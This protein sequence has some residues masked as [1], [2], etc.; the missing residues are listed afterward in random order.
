[1]FDHQLIPCA[2]VYVDSTWI[3][4]GKGVDLLQST[5]KPCERLDGRIFRAPSLATGRDC[6]PSVDAARPSLVHLASLP[7]P[8]DGDPQVNEEDEIADDWKDKEDLPILEMEMAS[9]VPFIRADKIKIIVLD[10]DAVL[11]TD[12]TLQEALTTIFPPSVYQFTEKELLD[13]YI[14]Y[15]ALQH[16]DGL[17]NSPR[18]IVQ[19]VTRYLG[20]VE[21]QS[22]FQDVLARLSKPSLYVDAPASISSLVESG[23]TIMAL[24]GAKNRAIV[25]RIPGISFTFCDAP[26]DDKPVT[27]KSLLEFCKVS[28]PNISMSEI[29][30]VTPNLHGVAEPAALAGF[31]TA[32][33]KC[34]RS[35]STKLTIP[36]FSPTYTVPGI[37]HI[38]P[39][40]LDSSSTPPAQEPEA[41][42]NFPPL[43]IRGC[44]QVTFTLS[45]GSYGFVWNGIQLS[46][47]A[48][49]AI[50]VEMIT[51]SQPSTLT[52]EAAIY[53]QLEGVKGIPMIHW[54]GL[55]SNAQL[56]VIEEIHSRGVI[57]HDIKPDNFAMGLLKDYKCLYLFDMG[58]CKLFLDPVT[59]KHMPFREGRGG[60]GTPRYSSHNVH[61]GLKPSRR[62]DIE[63]IGNLLLYLLHRELPWQGIY[64]PD[65][66]SK[67]R[68]IGE[69]KRGRH[70]TNLLSDSPSIF[71]QF[72]KHCRS[73]AFEDKPNYAY[74]R[75]LLRQT[76]KYDGWRFDW[77]YD[78]W[79]PGK[80]GTLLLEEY[81]FEERFL[82]PVRHYQD[83]L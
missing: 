8:H 20:T 62:D 81:K 58:L 5:L 69:M 17:R 33:I 43:R 66:P 32:F 51:S 49:V 42:K 1:M 16:A 82:Q 25:S 73:L 40:L 21:P 79:S 55:E 18:E 77:E 12:G 70:F 48:G 75:S 6:D 23:Y 53:V 78:W 36:T 38:L 39:I 59:G 10:C 54:S 63:A 71:T 13:L 2:T 57:V 11:N 68:Q 50:K 46:T 4:H 27:W 41:P 3:T 34:P 14:E 37:D 83:V 80:W 30:V 19:K 31:P 64:A 7:I 15:E 60:I 47:G 26:G 29:L 72:F 24:P 45:S 56:T 35:R 74:L 76:M 44:Y 52:Y 65:I 61:F 28:K 67:L 9:V 22:A